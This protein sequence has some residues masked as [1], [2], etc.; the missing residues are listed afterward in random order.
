MSLESV[1]AEKARSC[2]ELFELCMK[3]ES[4]SEWAPYVLSRFHTW[5]ENV[6]VIRTLS[7]GYTT[8]D[9]RLPYPQDLTEIIVNLLGDINNCL[10]GEF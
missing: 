6:A 2:Q 8:M 4:M 1:I 3:H 10:L 9:L 5:A 7:D